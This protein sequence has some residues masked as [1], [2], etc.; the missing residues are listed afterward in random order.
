MTEDKDTNSSATNN[1]PKIIRA[2]VVT[3]KN[4]GGARWE[5]DF[6]GVVTR[7]DIH[8]ITRVL[9]VEFAR[10]QRR[11]SIQ[12]KKV[13]IDA[14]EIERKAQLVQA[15]KESVPD[16]TIVP[17]KPKPTLKKVTVKETVQNG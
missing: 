1:H 16:T 5:V 10:A 14:I 9:R 8:R 15:E 7:R 2:K 17:P 3:I 4:T 13:A 12:R 11:Y 6:E